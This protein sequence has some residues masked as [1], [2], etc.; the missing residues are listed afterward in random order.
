MF[1]GP[2]IVTDGLV[3]IAD[4]INPKS[5]PGSGTTWYDVSGNLGIGTLVNGTSFNSEGYISTDGT[6]DYVSF[7][8]NLDAINNISGSD[9]FTFSALFELPEYAI[10]RETNSANFASL[11]MK[12]SYNSSFG[13]SLVY[14]LPSGGVH[15]RNRLY[16]GVRNLSMA[17]NESGY[18]NPIQYS[19]TEFLLNR[20]YQA[21][22]TSEFSGTTY[23]FKTYINGKLDILSTRSGGT[24]PVTFENTDALTVSGSPLGGNGINGFINLANCKVYNKALTAEEVQQNYNATKSRFNL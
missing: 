22:F 7:Y 16:S 10:Q 18:G 1:T 5:Y 17:S 8:G 15:T 13:M 2:D 21:D 23:T 4:A 12:G 3:F 19:T 11:L 14:D 20:W 9:P 6:N 24:Y